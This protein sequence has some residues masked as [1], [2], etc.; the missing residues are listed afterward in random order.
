MIQLLQ[1]Q[2]SKFCHD[3]AEISFR[4]KGHFFIRADIMK[5]I[6]AHLE[7][8]W[9]HYS[10]A[11][12]ILLHEV[13]LL[14]LHVQRSYFSSLFSRLE[15]DFILLDTA[16]LCS[17]LRRITGMYLSHN[18]IA[19]AGEHG[20]EHHSH[21]VSKE[22]QSK[23]PPEQPHLLHEVTTDLLL[24]MLWRDLE[25]DFADRRKNLYTTS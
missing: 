17:P 19:A 5:E 16:A 24:G 25:F 22:L 15:G 10:F 11:S 8:L 23:H 7:G 18:R 21:N 20:R 13:L 4:D 6:T 14:V 1:D 9:L 2:T 3:T 12:K